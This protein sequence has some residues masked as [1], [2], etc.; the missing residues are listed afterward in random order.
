MTLGRNDKCWCGSGL[1]YKRCHLGRENQTPTKSYERVAALRSNFRAKTCLHPAA[2]GKPCKSKIVRAHTVRRSADL[3]SVARDGHVYRISADHEVLVE[4]GGRPAARLIGIN[5]ASTFS[6][7]CARHDAETFRPLETSEFLGTKEQCFLLF[8]RA[9][10]RETYTKEASANSMSLF[11]NAD[12]GR[13]KEVQAAMQSFVGAMAEGTMKG[14]KDTRHFKS[15][16][17]DALL[18]RSF[19]LV[20]SRIIWFQHPLD[21]VCSG[22]T[23]PYWDFRGDT[24]QELTGPKLL[25]P[26]AITLL[27]GGSQGA[28]VLSWLEGYEGPPQ[29]FLESLLEEHRIGD[30]IIR[31]VFSALEN[32][33]AR[34]EWWDRLPAAYQQDLIRRMIEYMIPFRETPN[35]FLTDD[36]L[37]FVDWKIASQ[38]KS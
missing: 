29:T 33:F 8:F 35:D 7:F 2:A 30:A 5:S 6:G 34:P 38:D 26:L 13:P 9:W 22:A 15:L 17:D 20:K 24:L 4:T 23:Y 28:A 11:R 32:T 36:G 12:R 14:V 18:T 10:A 27:Q 37:E 31:F 25:S 3:E 21:V 16:L 19:D 1:K